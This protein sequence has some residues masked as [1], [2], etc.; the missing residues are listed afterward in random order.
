MRKRLV[1]I[2]AAIA[3]GTSL[4]AGVAYG[5]IP[6]PDGV[7]HAC[8]DGSGNIK[9]IDS[10]ATCPKGWTSVDWNQTGPQGPQGVQGEPGP[11]GAAGP[12]G[13]AGFMGYDVITQRVHVPWSGDW[14]QPSQFQM[15]AP[16]GKVILGAG[17]NL[18]PE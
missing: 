13:P 11:T 6:G 10:G 9:V 3:A 5:S 16:S 7:I 14:N 4:V 2:A 8:R 12:Q 18:N 15:M 1:I 17:Q